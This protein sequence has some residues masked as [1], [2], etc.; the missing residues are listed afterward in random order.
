M[1]LHYLMIIFF[2][3]LS[4]QHLRTRKIFNLINNCIYIVSNFF[5]EI[6]IKNNNLVYH[7]EDVFLLNRIVKN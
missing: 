7:K 1:S 6:C 2:S 4:S 3:R 5:Y